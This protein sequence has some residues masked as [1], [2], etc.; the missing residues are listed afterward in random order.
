MLGRR[1]VYLRMITINVQVLSDK[2]TRW[3]DLAN[4]R[5]G[6]VSRSFS[7]CQACPSPEP[8]RSF[9]APPSSSGGLPH[10]S[11]PSF[12]SSGSHRV[13]SCRLQ[14]ARQSL[15][16]YLLDRVLTLRGLAL[17]LVPVVTLTVLIVIAKVRGAGIVASGVGEVARRFVEVRLSG[18]GLLRVLG[19]CIRT[20]RL[21]AL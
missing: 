7:A 1:K 15:V 3:M 9:S 11:R 8:C 19:L 12:R 16:R 20:A 10:Q 2:S 5:S 13:A 21:I 14:Q 6:Q 17:E 4:Q 18:L